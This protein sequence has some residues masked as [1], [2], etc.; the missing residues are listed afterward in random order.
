MVKVTVLYFYQEEKYLGLE[1][2]DV[3]YKVYYLYTELQRAHVFMTSW[4]PSLVSSSHVEA[5]L[6]PSTACGF[7]CTQYVLHRRT[8]VQQIQCR[9]SHKVHTACCCM[10]F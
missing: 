10:C 7:W 8:Y 2:K 9:R 3:S 4:Q 5:P 6:A 1:K